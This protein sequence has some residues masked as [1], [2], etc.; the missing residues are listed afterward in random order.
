MSP[1]RNREQLYRALVTDED[2][3]DF[4]GEQAAY[5]NISNFFETRFPDLSLPE[6]IIRM[7]RDFYVE[8]STD[9]Q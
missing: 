6:I 9:C 4:Q 5:E 7:F 8:N 2:V 1:F 3:A